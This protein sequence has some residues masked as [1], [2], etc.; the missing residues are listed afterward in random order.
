MGVA[1]VISAAFD[2]TFQQ[3]PEFPYFKSATDGKTSCFVVGTKFKGKSC[4]IAKRCILKCNIE[5]NLV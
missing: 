5:H 1:V 3:S 4:F 2:F